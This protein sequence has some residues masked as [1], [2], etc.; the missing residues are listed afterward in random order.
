MQAIAQTRTMQPFDFQLRP[1]IIFGEGVVARL[2]E[3]ARQI[4]G[5][6]A[7]L[8]SDSGVVDAGHFDT[9]RRYLES[10]GLQVESFHDFQENPDTN[11]VQVGVAVAR[12]FQPDI[13]IG[14]G[15]GSSIDC[16]KGINFVY[17]CGGAMRDYRGVGK[18]TA[19]MLPMIAVPTTAG[20][21]S[22]SQSFAL[23]SDA[24]SHVKMAC[25]DPRAACRV[26]LLDPILTI[27]QPGTVTA[28][29][30]IDA[31][32]HAVETYV[33]KPRNAI[34][35]TFSRRAFG[36]LAM[37]FP[38]VLREPDN[39]EAR[40]RMQIGACLA[41]LAIETSMLGAAHALG[42]PLTARFN[43]VHGQAVGV[44]LPH[45]VRLNGQRFANW[46]AE[47]L[48]EIEPVIAPEQAPQR[49][50]DLLT[51]YLRQAKLATDLASLSVPESAFDQLV[52]D[53]GEQWTGT[54]NPVELNPTTLR[55][56]Y[57]A[58]LHDRDVP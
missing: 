38:K 51:D 1:R 52:E 42:N 27:T 36:L 12:R 50:A 6:R 25:G 9:G 34:S 4:G 45:V 33:T 47:L 43:V 55:G 14:L 21:G 58:A 37:G 19:D 49:M 48:S 26:A 18:A 15:G 8:V 53:A 29:T 46:Y 13:L 23:I 24:D 20:T 22:E 32:S 5:K 57:A 44:M 54:F 39:L 7:L 2:G 11:M 31:L 28:L 10:A 41:G 40:S 16:C 17:S 3:L 56:L 30:G 35:V